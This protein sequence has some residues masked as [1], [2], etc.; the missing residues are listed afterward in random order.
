MKWRKLASG[1]LLIGIFFFFLSCDSDQVEPGVEVKLREITQLE[2]ELINNTN[3]FALDILQLADQTGEHKNI[4]L[5]PLSIGMAM[6]MLFNGAEG[7]TQRQIQSALGFELFDQ[8]DLNKTFN[9]LMSLL[10]IIDS[11]VELKLANS[12][13]YSKNYN[14]H[15]S[16]RDRVMA[17]YDA[18]IRD[19]DFAKE[20]AVAAINR[21]GDLKTEG[22]IPEL[23]A[24]IPPETVMT[25]I[26]AIYFKALWFKQFDPG[27]TTKEL[28]HISKNMAEKTDMMHGNTM[29]VR[30]YRNNQVSYVELPFGSGQFSLNIIM[31]IEEIGIDKFVNT[32]TLSDIESFSESSDSMDIKLSLPV[33][34][35]EFEQKLNDVLGS[36]GITKAFT[37]L[38]DLENLFENDV[39]VKVS[40]VRHKA[41]IEVDEHGSEAAAA[42]SIGIVPTSLPVEVKFNH[43]FLFLISERHTGAFLF[44]G[45]LRHP[46]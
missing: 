8:R 32:L 29:P 3:D 43:P 16:F 2:K 26:N 22:H 40:E 42:T 28:F 35:I 1:G 6:G 23:V 41:V 37:D 34:R 30:I 45:I 46:S 10:L 14:I 36:L 12:I 13:W 19:M 18:E 33:F 44:T 7:E 25:L 39:P 38:A 15:P 24:S 17:Y 11:K 31:P 9:E 20:T 5:S 21:W 4:F 27:L